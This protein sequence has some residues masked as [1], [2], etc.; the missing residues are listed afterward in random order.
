M[1]KYRAQ[2]IADIMQY[3]LDYVR[4]IREEQSE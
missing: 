4:K 1:A 2:T 3:K